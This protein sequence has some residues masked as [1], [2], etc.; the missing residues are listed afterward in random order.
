V[1]DPFSVTFEACAPPG[2]GDAEVK[3]AVPQMLKIEPGTFRILMPEYERVNFLGKRGDGTAVNFEKGVK[4]LTATVDSR[5]IKREKVTFTTFAYL[6][7]VD[8]AIS[9]VPSNATDRM[10]PS[11]RF[12]QDVQYNSG[13]ID[14]KGK[15]LK[16][17][18]GSWN[19]DTGVD[20]RWLGGAQGFLRLMDS[21]GLGPNLG[22]TVA[23]RQEFALTYHAIQGVQAGLNGNYKPLVE[24][25]IREGASAYFVESLFQTW[26]VSVQSD[27]PL[28]YLSWG[29][30]LVLTLGAQGNVVARLQVTKA[31]WVPSKSP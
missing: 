13:E 27:K 8:A 1:A 11:Y 24:K 26:L 10:V 12:A 14:A 29:I 17:N 23:E 15:N 30:R 22:A 28:G 25:A 18:Y 5:V 21:P 19:A 3:D 9:F 20:Q 7:G 16:V 4:T 6:K 2:P 31:S